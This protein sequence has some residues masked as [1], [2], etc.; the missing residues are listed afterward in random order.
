VLLD[1]F[2]NTVSQI[3]ESK[4]QAVK[5]VRDSVLD[6]VLAQVVGFTTSRDVT[7]KI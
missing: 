4:K 2:I 7:S 5:T 6:P 3:K 1:E